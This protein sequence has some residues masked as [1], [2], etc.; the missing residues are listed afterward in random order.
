MSWKQR[1]PNIHSKTHSKTNNLE[2]ERH[3]QAKEIEWNCERDLL[4]EN[5][6]QLEG[7]I[8]ELEQLYKKIVDKSKEQQEQQQKKQVEKQ[9]KKIKSIRERIKSNR[10]LERQRREEKKWA[11]LSKGRSSQV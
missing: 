9:I 10:T 11:A 1:K 7:R 4:F 2:R 3:W 8:R 5:K 6:A